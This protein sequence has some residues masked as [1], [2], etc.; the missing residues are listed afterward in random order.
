MAF[1]WVGVGGDE[2][3]KEGEEP[4]KIEPPVI[5]SGI[6]AIGEAGNVIQKIDSK[7]TTSRD[8]AIV[9]CDEPEPESEVP[10]K[11]GFVK[12]VNVQTIKVN[13]GTGFLAI[14]AT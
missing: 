1:N 3:P 12:T 9:H 5:E 6:M 7:T 11:D 2:E 8:K 14:Y 10:K 13:F 4:P